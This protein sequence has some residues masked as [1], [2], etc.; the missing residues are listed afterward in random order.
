MRGVVG[1]LVGVSLLG[2]TACQTRGQTNSENTEAAKTA[3]APKAEGQSLRV[4]VVGPQQGALSS[5]R[6]TGVT[7]EPA[8]QSSVA[9]GATARVARVLTPEG[10]RVTQGQVMVELDATNARNALRQAQ[11]AVEQA[12]I[13]LT[14][15]QRS[16][17]NGLPGQQASLSAAQ[18]GY[19]VAQRRLEES[20]QLVNVGGISRIELRNAEAALDQ[21]KA[22]LDNARE[23]VNRSQ[24]AG[25]EDIALLQV[26][27]QQAQAQRDQAQSNL[28]ETRVKAPFAGVVAE[29][30]VNP[31]EFV[32]TGARVVRL[33]D[34]SR[35]EATF[36]L[37]PEDAAKLAV[38]STL[39]V[40][41]QGQAYPAK[42]VRTTKVP[43]T[44]RLVELVANLSAPIAPGST[45]TVGYTLVL[46]RGLLI[47][48][49]AIQIE[50]RQAYVYALE[51]D[52]VARVNV[53]RVA[54]D[55]ARAVVEGL[56]ASSRIVFP[57]P[58]SL[59]AGDRVEVIP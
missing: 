59:G 48:S 52:K 44:D 26:A 22:V 18:T 9:A 34:T 23:A 47:P 40:T 21:A 45:A 38:G 35:L 55:G 10:T 49:G 54:D 13:N 16:T 33:A 42:L 4:R 58:A 37:P 19:E 20:R 41:S 24:R 3:A 32:T 27:L 8:R 12:Q 43:G 15:S 25:S 28:A 6:S 31:G 17:S 1:V 2:L 56:T 57:V 14:R 29:V 7:V 11:L 53:R 5:P 30:V 46:A 50:G 39:R 51:G 36:R